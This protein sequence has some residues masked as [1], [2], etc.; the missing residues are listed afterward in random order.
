MKYSS[1]PSHHQRIHKF[2][3]VAEGVLYPHKTIQ[4]EDS[5]APNSLNGTEN[6]RFS[7]KSTRNGSLPCKLNRQR[8]ETLRIIRSRS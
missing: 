8:R 6:H 3:R 2:Y 7:I 4:R 1:D 5:L